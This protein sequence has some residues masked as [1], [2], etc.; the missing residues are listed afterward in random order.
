MPALPAFALQKAVSTTIRDFERNYWTGVVYTTN[1]RLWEH[2]EDFKNDCATCVASPSIWKPPRSLSRHLKNQMPAGALLL[3]SDMPMTSE[4]VKT[5]AS[6]R[7]V[8]ANFAQD[9][10][11]DRGGVA[12]TTNQ[13]GKGSST[14]VSKPER[15]FRHKKAG[16]PGFNRM[17]RF[18]Y[19]ESTR[20]LF[21]V[22][23]IC[24]GVSF[25]FQFLNGPF[26]GSLSL[27]RSAITCARRR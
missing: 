12:Q 25:Q 8:T 27:V 23:Q 5:E 17:T 9:T 15:W 7:V 1:K 10:P 4:G 16:H 20:S 13:P 3:V 21:R 22:F 26:C 6:N 18:F 24:A 11:D 14:C 19:R 2:R